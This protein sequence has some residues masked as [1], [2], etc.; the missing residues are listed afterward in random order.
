MALAVAPPKEPSSGQHI[1]DPVTRR[2]FYYCE[3]T[4]N[5]GTQNSN[6]VSFRMGEIPEQEREAQKELIAVN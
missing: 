2:R 6:C 3:V 4:T 1:E 5:A